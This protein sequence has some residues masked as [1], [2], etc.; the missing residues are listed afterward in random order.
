MMHCLNLNFVLPSYTDNNVSD[1]RYVTL[2]FSG[3]SLSLNRR[4]SAPDLFT[5]QLLLF[6]LL[7]WKRKYSYRSMRP[8]LFLHSI[9]CTLFHLQSLNV[10]LETSFHCAIIAIS[11]TSITT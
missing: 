5:N 6:G 3:I 1:Y 8:D 4:L 11:Y 7:L 9:V 2:K 10:F